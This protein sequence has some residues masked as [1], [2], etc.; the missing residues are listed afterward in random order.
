MSIAPGTKLS[1]EPLAEEHLD[2]IMKIEK[3]AYPEPW[4]VGM[5]REEIRSRRSCFY[6][7]HADGALVGYSGFWLVLDE[8]H[9][10]SLTVEAG[11]RGMGFGREQLLHLLAQGEENGVRAFTLEVRESNAPARSLYESLGFRTVGLRKGYYSTTQED[12][13][14]MLKEMA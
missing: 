9:I 10:T 1:Y 2:A 13:I 8:A 11:H 6:V 14:V 3:E 12:A 5:F 4:T 7:A